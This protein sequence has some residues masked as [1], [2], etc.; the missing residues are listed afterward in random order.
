MRSDRPSREGEGAVLE[1]P[2][3][4]LRRMTPDDLEPLLEVFGDPEAMR[5]YPA[6]FTRT[7]MKEWI[8]WNLRNYAEHGYGL[9]V[10]GAEGD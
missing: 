5:H 10:P 3:L 9:L 7:Q 2:R 6:P 1:T 4:V 8:D